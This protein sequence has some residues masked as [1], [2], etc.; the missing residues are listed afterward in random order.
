M[1][2][3]KYTFNWMHLRIPNRNRYNIFALPLNIGIFFLPFDIC[4]W[5]HAMCISNFVMDLLANFHWSFDNL[6][7]TETNDSVH[8]LISKC[9]WNDRN[10]TLD[11]SIHTTPSSVLSVRTIF[12][13]QL[14]VHF[15]RFL[16]LT[17]TRFR[18]FIPLF[19]F[20]SLFTSF[21]LYG[22]VLAA[23]PDSFLL[24]ALSI[25]CSHLYIL[26]LA[27][28]FFFC[29]CFIESDSQDL[30]NVCSVL[31]SFFVHVLSPCI[32]SVTAFIVFS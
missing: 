21:H 20:F 25:S 18:Y 5:L 24:L 1:I 16:W 13:H 22:M 9:G 8:I 32:L 15:N 23:F 31:S 14:C 27:I 6:Q 17:S 19:V 10:T 2:K 26:T 29:G 11:A 7:T 12:S 28:A 30:S 4:Y 3:I